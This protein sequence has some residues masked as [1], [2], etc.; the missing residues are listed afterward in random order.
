MGKG[1]LFEIRGKSRILNS[2][3]NNEKSHPKN[4]SL[5]EAEIL[6]AEIQNLKSELMDIDRAFRHRNFIFERF[7]RKAS[8][9]LF[10]K[11]TGIRFLIK[12][13][14]KLNNSINRER[15]EAFHRQNQVLQNI[16]DILKGL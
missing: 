11:Y 3:I 12:L 5:N 9:A 8:I 6:K 7:E 13:I 10:M 16:L 1:Q 2:S 14:I 4:A 15:D